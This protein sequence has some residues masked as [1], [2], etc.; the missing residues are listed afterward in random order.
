MRISDWSSDVCSSDLIEHGRIV[1]AVATRLHDHAARKSEMVAQR[2][3][4]LRPRIR[5]HIFCLGAERELRRR[6]EYMAMRINR[7]GRRHEIRLR[8]IA[9]PTYRSEERR[10]GKEGGST[11][12]TRG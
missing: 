10:L 2:E 3:Q 5:R 8:G 12:R 11:C 9:M 6:A 1:G 7:T 4:H